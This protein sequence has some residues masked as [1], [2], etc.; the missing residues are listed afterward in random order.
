MT[1][2]KLQNGQ[3]AVIE[4]IAHDKDGHW[5]KLVCFGLLPGAEVH[6]CQRWPAFVIRVGMTE[7]GLDQ[8]T[9]QLVTLKV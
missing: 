4:S 1:L 5:R 2:D 6:M 9:A 8:T 3:T 7:V